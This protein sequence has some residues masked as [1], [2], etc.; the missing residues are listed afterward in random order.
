M[1]AKRI[2]SASILAAAL[3][4]TASGALAAGPIDEPTRASVKALVKLARA[5]GQ[6]QP[7]GEAILPLVVDAYPEP[8][9]SRRQ[10]RDETLMARAHGQLV[11]A[12]E[13]TM[14]VAPTGTQ[15]ARADV[16]EDVRQARLH[17]ELIPAGEGLGPVEY[18]ARARTFRGE[19][20]AM[21]ARR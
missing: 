13:G 18:Q 10:V 20:V 14:F 7:A 1:T 5:S 12:G 11:P 19:T 3:A 2:F 8:A 17:G 4:A 21:R 15:L 16:R 9:L 6:L